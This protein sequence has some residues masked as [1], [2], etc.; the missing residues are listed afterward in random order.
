MIWWLPFL[1]GVLWIGR[2]LRGLGSQDH[3]SL[4]MAA[5]LF[6]LEALSAKRSLP[7]NLAK[8][9]PLDAVEE[10]APHA[11]S[12]WSLA[13]Y[14][15]ATGIPRQ[16][17]SRKLENLVKSGQFVF[18]GKGYRPQRASLAP[19]PQSI[20]VFGLARWL[21]HADGHDATAFRS[22]ELVKEWGALVRHYISAYLALVKPRRS[23]SGSISDVSVQLAIGALHAAEVRRYCDLNGPR[24]QP[25]FENYR[26][27]SPHVI[28]AP[29]S[30]RKIAQLC[31]ISVDKCRN[32]CRRLAT[33]Q[34][35][36]RITG[37]E[38]LVLDGPWREEKISG[39]R[40]LFTEEVELHLGR[41]LRSLALSS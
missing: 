28:D 19:F 13:T 7:T 15:E 17:A 23:L 31:G 24:S 26:A 33:I 18:D 5:N 41:F 9:Q 39:C 38:Y 29:H 40:T 36:V 8:E 4:Y 37:A 30:L 21:L 20:P 16:T 11:L 3:A 34:K 12:F 27:L 10:H 25:D 2:E 14:A 35:V 1:E 32:E 22:P 6:M